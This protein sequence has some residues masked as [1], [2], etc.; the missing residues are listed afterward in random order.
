MDYELL[1]SKNSKTNLSDLCSNVIIPMALIRII[2]ASTC[3][4]LTACCRESPMSIQDLFSHWLYLR[5]TSTTS[6]INSLLHCI[7]Y[8][9]LAIQISMLDKT[10][11]VNKVIAEPDLHVSTTK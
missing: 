4:F 6:R 5:F 2:L 1:S 10:K 3:L 9:D 7:V 11:P 8:I